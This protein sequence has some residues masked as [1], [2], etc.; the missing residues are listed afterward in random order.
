[1]KTDERWFAE[2][3]NDYTNEVIAGYLAASGR[4]ADGSVKSSMRDLKGES[5]QLWELP[6]NDIKRLVDSKQNCRLDFKIFV[7]QANRGN[8]VREIS[9]TVPRGSVRKSIPVGKARTNLLEILSNK[10]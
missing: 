5:H 3:M 8:L 4:S 7:L 10:R 2:A 1:M 6:A 9:Y